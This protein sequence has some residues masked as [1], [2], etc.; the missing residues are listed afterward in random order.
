[1]IKQNR[2]FALSDFFSYFFLLVNILAVPLLLDPAVTNPLLISKE[3]LFIG[4]VLLN[5]LVW[6]SKVILSKKLL[7]VQSVVDKPIL[8][9][10]ASA[11]VSAFFS[12][13][14]TDS[15]LGRN[16]YFI[17]HFTLL[18][19]L[20]V[21][22]FLLIEH[23]NTRERWARALDTLIVSGGI[24]ATLFFIKVFFH[25][26][27]LV[28][29]FPNMWNTVDVTNTS[30][31]IW[32]ATIFLISAGQIIK[33]D[34]V[35]GRIL[36]YFFVAIVSFL[37]I[38]ALNFLVIWWVLL[39]GLVLLLL[40]G[41]SSLKEARLGWLSTLFALLILVII[42]IVFGAPKSLQSVVPVEATLSRHSSWLIASDTIFG[43]VKNLII[44]SGLGS[45]AID[46]SQFRDASFNDDQ[47]AWSL[48]FNRPYSSALALVAEGGLMVTLLWIFLVLFMIGHILT[49]WLK[50]RAG[51][52]DHEDRLLESLLGNNRPS[53]HP[54]YLDVF[55][56]AVPWFV[57]SF[58]V[59]LVFYGPVLWWLWWLLLG[60]AIS[61]LALFNSGTTSVKESII[62]DTPEHNLSF[63][64]VFI[65]II[66]AVCILGVWGTRLYLA[67]KMYSTALRSGTFAD[68]EQKLQE[69]ITYRDN[70]DLYHVARA[71]NYLV[72][73]IRLSKVAKPDVQKISV[74]LGQAINEARRATDLSPRSVAIWEN[75]ATMYENAAVL[76]PDARDWAMKSLVQAKT[77][78]P[79]NPVL[80]WRLGNN[81]SL[82]GNWPEAI[83]NYQ[84]AVS[85]KKDHIGAY[86]GLANAY[87][88]TREVDKAI[89]IYVGIAPLAQNDVD[90]LFNFGR[91]LYNR[92]ANGKDDRNDAEKLW[93]EVVRRQANYSNA[94]YSLGLLY[95]SRGDK[96]QALEY[97][98]K[99]KE[100]NPGNKDIT[101]KIT[102]LIGQ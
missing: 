54:A 76:V 38:V 24:T 86:V 97:Y 18:L 30:F 50:V 56:L 68:V 58:G 28:R 81:Y 43:S 53:D 57:V 63:S 13:T 102:H 99:V 48:R 66:S 74:L 67:E 29:W 88:Q 35:P 71:Q 1:M 21:F 52:L 32:L 96:T 26:D 59:A 9:L 8:L 20:A 12:V 3:Y 60:L 92:N 19:F 23:L 90:Y 72:E 70:V 49:A 101:T 44:G 89:A 100:L 61:G 83:K 62:E 51:G 2:L 77:L 69:A 10:I 46:F 36:I 82:A 80:A 78:E 55:L 39:V 34:L 47:Y 25:L 64:F 6:T 84:E 5:M 4:L 93:I 41:V 22:C 15:F 87:E 85:L 91:L 7:Y 17:F 65:I 94:L 27:P 40:V 14:R 73:A 31:G 11:L 42:F 98:Y 16:D 33:K 37:S 75:L 95:E 45:F 79:T